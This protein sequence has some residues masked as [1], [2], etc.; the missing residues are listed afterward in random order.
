MHDVCLSSQSDH[1]L[2]IASMIALDTLLMHQ[3]VGKIF[4]RADQN[5]TV[6][7]LPNLSKLFDIPG[8][9]RKYSVTVILLRGKTC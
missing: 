4:C 9:G 3:T 5:N 7:F 2:F 8:S 1:K 6:I